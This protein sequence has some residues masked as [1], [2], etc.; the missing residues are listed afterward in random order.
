MSKH[1]AQ[2]SKQRIST[3]ERELQQE[4]MRIAVKCNHRKK[5]GE[6]NVESTDRK[7][8]LRC[9]HCGTK[10]SI[11]PFTEQELRDHTFALNSAIQQIRSLSNKDTDKALIR[12]LGELAENTK[13]IGRLYG[14]TVERVGKKKG[15]GKG[16]KKKNSA[17]QFGGLI[18]VMKG[19]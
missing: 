8:V 16:G 3:L 14:Q 15:K 9:R 19:K 12:E 6:L 17:G 10:F 11:K 1:E 7:H 2:E 4:K 18:E 5:N 13:A